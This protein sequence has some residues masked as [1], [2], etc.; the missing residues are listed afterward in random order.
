MSFVVYWLRPSFAR[1]DDEST[2]AFTRSISM[3]PGEVGQ[4]EVNDQSSPPGDRGRYS[5]TQ[6]HTK[7]RGLQCTFGSFVCRR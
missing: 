7:R 5:L 1:K 6:R 4:N 2:L 3:Q